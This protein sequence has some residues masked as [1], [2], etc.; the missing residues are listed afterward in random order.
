MCVCGGVVGGWGSSHAH[1]TGLAAYH[2]HVETFFIHI[3]KKKEKKEGEAAIRYCTQS[4]RERW[5]AGPTQLWLSL[6]LLL[7]G[8]N[9]GNPG[10]L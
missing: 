2:A 4:I 9:K 3:N 8:A 1:Y 7:S 10:A 5:R 6:Y